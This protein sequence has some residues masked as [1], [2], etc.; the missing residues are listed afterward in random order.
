MASERTS[1]PIGPVI[2]QSTACAAASVVVPAW[3]GLSA[4]C[5]ARKANGTQSINTKIKGKNFF[6]NGFILFM[7]VSDDLTQRCAG[8]RAALLLLLENPRESKRQR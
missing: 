8:A 3:S 7:R 2:S 1:P 5:P 4:A 6:I